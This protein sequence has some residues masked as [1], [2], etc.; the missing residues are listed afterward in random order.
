MTQYPLIRKAAIT[1]ISGNRQ[2]ARDIIDGLDVPTLRA[3]IE[4][5]EDIRKGDRRGAP[6]RFSDKEIADAKVMCADAI[7]AQ[8]APVG[9]TKIGK[10]LRETNG[11]RV[12]KVTLESPRK[13][14]KT[15]NSP[16]HL[17]HVAHSAQ[18][19]LD[20][21]KARFPNYRVTVGQARVSDLTANPNQTAFLYAIE[22]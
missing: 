6:Q 13:G 18:D 5:I 22:D 16:S 14:G 8:S 2:M 21:I 3:M 12:Y 4:E 19:V 9:E 1:V 7:A 17:F 15:F 20:H 10:A 11:K